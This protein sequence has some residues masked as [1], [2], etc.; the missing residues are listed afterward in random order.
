MEKQL[1]SWP[2]HKRQKKKKGTESPCPLEEH[3][4]SDGKF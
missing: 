2:G 4:S 3:I 1:I